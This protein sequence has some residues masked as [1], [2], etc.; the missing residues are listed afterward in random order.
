MIV[1]PKQGK[2]QWSVEGIVEAQ[3]EDPRIKDQAIQWVPF[4][5]MGE[6][7]DKVKWLM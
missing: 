3:F 6:A 5:R 2:V 4:I 7:G 1:K